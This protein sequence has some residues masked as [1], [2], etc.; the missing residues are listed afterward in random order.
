[1][2]WEAAYLAGE[3]PWDKGAAAP[4][5]S[6]ILERGLLRGRVLVPGCG[7]GH[8]ARAIAAKAHGEVVGLDVAPTAVLRARS[9]AGFGNLAFE[10]GD[11]FALPEA[12]KGAFDAV[13]EHTCFCAIDPALR[14]NYVLALGSALRTGG[15]LVGVF[16]LNPSMDGRG[17]GPPFGVSLEELDELMGAYFE[18]LEEWA[19]LNCFEGREG[20]EWCRRYRRR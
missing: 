16:Y 12:W 5:L 3:T 13:W 10:E 4:E 15:E 11:L 14:S 19:P 18:L 6:R 9:I 8:D 17:D 2:E 20:R 7:L 1:M